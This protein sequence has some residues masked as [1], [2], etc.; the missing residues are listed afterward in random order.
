L[1]SWLP[2]GSGGKDASSMENA[3]LKEP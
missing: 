2:S 3:R 1:A